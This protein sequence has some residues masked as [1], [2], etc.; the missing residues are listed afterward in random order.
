MLKELREQAQELLQ[1]GNSKEQAKGE[2]MMTVINQIED[3]YV[4]RATSITWSIEDFELRAEKLQGKRWKEVFNEEL[5]QENLE[6]MINN[7]D[8]NYGVA[9]ES[10]DFYL[11]NYCRK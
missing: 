9:W 5:F 3:N 7:H 11:E 4:P 2:G 6:E 1:C 10:I 8:A